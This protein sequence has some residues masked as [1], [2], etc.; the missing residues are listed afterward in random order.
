MFELD[1]VT[2]LVRP[3]ALAASLYSILVS[4]SHAFDSSDRKILNQPALIKE[5]YST[6]EKLKELGKRETELKK[7][8][9][10]S[11]TEL[12]TLELVTDNQIYN[13]VKQSLDNRTRRFNPS[14]ASSQESD[15]FYESSIRIIRPKPIIKFDKSTG[16]IFFLYESNNDFSGVDYKFIVGKLKDGLDVEKLKTSNVSEIVNNIS[17]GRI[18]YD[19]VEREYGRIN[20]FKSDSVVILVNGKEEVELRSKSLIEKKPGINKEYAL[21]LSG[22]LSELLKDINTAE[23]ENNNLEKRIA[24]TESKV[25]TIKESISQKKKRIE[26]I[27]LETNAPLSPLAEDIYL[28]RMPLS[29]IDSTYSLS[30]RIGS[31]KDLEDFY[32]QQGIKYNISGI[33]KSPNQVLNSKEAICWEFALLNYVALKG[34]V[35][36]L[37]YV[38]VFDKTKEFGHAILTFKEE[39]VWKYASNTKVITTNAKNFKELISIAARDSDFNPKS[40]TFYFTNFNPD[41]QFPKDW[42]KL[43]GNQVLPYTYGKKIN[44]L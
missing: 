26:T 29:E 25:S 28:R 10:N 9:N 15:Y 40:K 41:S 20:T 44:R 33:N 23:K 6:S 27:L 35:K 39:G 5:A 43:D 13:E 2:K 36:N 14:Y 18:Y 4:Y 11:E 8:A 37:Q 19:S 21:S 32:I 12:K 1:K 24:F 31:S 16:T 30:K 38:S 22:M 7:K 42:T 3:I 34:K 17:S